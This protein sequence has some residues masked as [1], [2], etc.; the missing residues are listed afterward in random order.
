M[1]PDGRRKSVVHLLPDECGARI[2][3]SP[4][5]YQ[6]Q[7]AIVSAISNALQGLAIRISAIAYSF[8]VGRVNPAIGDVTMLR[9]PKPG[10]CEDP[11]ITLR[12]FSGDTV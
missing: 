12:G 3:V 2:Q 11:S 7:S 6:W 9:T 4:K 5:A 8:S 1:G 10:M